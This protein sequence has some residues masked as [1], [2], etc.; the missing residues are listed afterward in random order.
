MKY[1]KIMVEIWGDVVEI[2]DLLIS[3]AFSSVFTIVSYFL[4]PSNNKTRE[5]FYGMLGAVI[6]FI[7]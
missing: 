3:I 4:A 6:G 2:K 1:K 7:I 5:L